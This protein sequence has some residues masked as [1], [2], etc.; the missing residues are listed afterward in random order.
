MDVPS[1]T[2]EGFVLQATEQ[3]TL[4]LPNRDKKVLRV[5]IPAELPQPANRDSTSVSLR[6]YVLCWQFYVTEYSISFSVVG[7]GNTELVSPSIVESTQGL[8]TGSCRVRLDTCNDEE[9]PL[10]LVFDNTFSLIRSKSLSYRV[11]LVK[12][13]TFSAA[14]LAVEAIILREKGV[15]DDGDESVSNDIALVKMGQM[16]SPAP[17][18]F[19]APDQQSPSPWTAEVEENE[20]RA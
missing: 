3:K 10:A 12:P 18:S 14:M 2:A 20:D 1:R 5:D 6:Q 17:P 7:P 16:H 15:S 9:R 19:Y 11:I 4:F 13:N 8:Q